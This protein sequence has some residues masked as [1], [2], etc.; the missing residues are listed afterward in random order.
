MK[1]RSLALA[2]IAACGMVACG[3][4]GGG[5]GDSAAVSTTGAAD[6]S[7]KMFGFSASSVTEPAYTG[8]LADDGFAWTNYRRALIGLPAYARNTALDLAAR[9]HSVYVTLNGYAEGHFETLGNPGFSG[10]T[11]GSR[12]AAAGYAGT[13]VDE[14]GS[15]GIISNAVE[16]IDGLIDAPYHRSSQ[17]G[18]FNEAGTGA[19][20]T[21]T[22]GAYFVDFGGRNQAQGVP[23]G[24]LL[25]FPGSQ[26]V[27]A[28]IA[29]TVRESPSPV[30]DLDG[31]VVG[32]PIS[33]D[34]CRE[35]SMQLASFSL[36]DAGGAAVN[37]RLVSTISGLPLRYFA[38]WIPLQ[39][40]TGGT[41]Y[42]AS[43]S[44][45]LDNTPFSVAW[46]I[47]TGT[48]TAVTYT[49]SA[50][51]LASS[52][53]NTL[54]VTA[55]AGTGNPVQLSVAT[56]RYFTTTYLRPNTALLTR[57]ATACAPLVESCFISAAGTDS[58]GRVG[59]N[60]VVSVQ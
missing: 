46:Q 35:S 57:N 59:S 30:P 41:T 27:N 53:G 7:I 24:Q 14:N 56:S 28:P 12:A 31:T 11:P 29:W 60:F 4:G 18:P 55:S 6:S 37:G 15:L 48:V 17:F 45:T 8:N 21:A 39:P 9:R 36:K 22:R 51:A 2:T 40:L 1:T 10:V 26:S 3:G 54:T 43:A 42:T 5:G 20:I 23:C 58:L 49:A 47:T 32:Y 33:L 38:F 13:T 19:D 50:A 52:S 25:A 16:A 44:G 34:A